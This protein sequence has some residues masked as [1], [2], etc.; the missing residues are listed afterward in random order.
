MVRFFAVLALSVFAFGQP[1]AA[2]ADSCSHPDF[3]HINSTT[4]GFRTPT[5]YQRC[6]GL[7]YTEA[8]T[9]LYIE[10]FAVP[11]GKDCVRD[12][13]S[14][15][16]SLATALYLRTATGAGARSTGSLDD[17][18]TVLANQYSAMFYNIFKATYADLYWAA[19]L[20]TNSAENISWAWMKMVEFD[21]FAEF[22]GICY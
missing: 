20:D 11:P 3:I 5:G 4:K 2:A 22:G 6:I 18:I 15:V 12:S 14:G 1:A 16:T 13:A 10:F 7:R 8:T 17:P 9:E 21:G 19:I